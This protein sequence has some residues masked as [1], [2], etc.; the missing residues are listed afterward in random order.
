M[1]NNLKVLSAAGASLTF[2]APAPAKK[3]GPGQPRPLTPAFFKVFFSIRDFKIDYLP[4]RYNVKSKHAVG[5]SG[6][7][8]QTP[9]Q[10]KKQ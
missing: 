8:G 3:V 5:K 4:A 7:V 1:T 2:K 6:F 9:N 10:L